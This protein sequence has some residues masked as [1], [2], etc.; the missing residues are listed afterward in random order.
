MPHAA[1]QPAPHRH[2]LPNG[3]LHEPGVPEADART[4]S[5]CHVFVALGAMSGFMFIATVVLWLSG[6]ANS[7]FI[8]DHGREA[9]NFAISM[10]LWS[11]VLAV[12]IVGLAFAWIP[13]LFMIIMA[14][15]SAVLA[16]KREYVRYPMTLRIL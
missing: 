4:A 9:C 2:L 6:R 8:D 11:I 1:P 13:W 10:T 16:S 7:P 5:L 14:I 12:S 15:R 3:R